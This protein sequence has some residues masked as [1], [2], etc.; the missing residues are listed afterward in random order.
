[1]HHITHYFSSPIVN[2][3]SL[4]KATQSLPAALDDELGTC[5]HPPPFPTPAPF[6]KPLTM[7]LED[8]TQSIV[9]QFEYSDDDVNKAVK[10]FLRQMGMCSDEDSSCNWPVNSY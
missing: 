8:E 5:E 7:A 6:S 4:L 10:E 1:L 9:E 2:T 3:P